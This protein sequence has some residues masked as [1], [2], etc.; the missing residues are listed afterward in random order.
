MRRYPAIFLRASVQ[1]LISCVLFILGDGGND[2]MVAIDL[3][4]ST[5]NSIVGNTIQG[6]SGNGHAGIKLNGAGSTIAG[7]YLSGLT[8]GIY[9]DAG[10]QNVVEAAN[11]FDGITYQVVGPGAGGVTRR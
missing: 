1:T 8:Y 6:A 11:N 4:P 3:G 7:N 5:G 9:A 2:N 10:T